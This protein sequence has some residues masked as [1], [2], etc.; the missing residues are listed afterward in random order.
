MFNFLKYFWWLLQCGSFE[1]GEISDADSYDSLSDLEGKRQRILMLLQE[2][3]EDDTQEESDRDNQEE[4][5]TDN[6]EESNSDDNSKNP[7][8]EHLEQKVPEESPEETVTSSNESK[9]LHRSHAIESH[10]GAF[11]PESCT[12]YTSLPNAEKW[13]V[14]ISDH[15][16]H[17]NL[18]D[19]LGTWN[20]MKGVME[21]VKKRKR[22]MKGSGWRTDDPNKLSTRCHLHYGA[23]HT[24]SKIG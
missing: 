20:K 16:P 17:E 12:P 6:Q 18:P 24:V 22:D 11:V 2:E 4:S 15:V 23:W 3:S 21:M 8:Q 7:C 10:L 5:D 9:R 13:S 19:A 14:D 1:E